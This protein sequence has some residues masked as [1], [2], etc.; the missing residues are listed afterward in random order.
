MTRTKLWLALASCLVLHSPSARAAA[1]FQDLLVQPPSIGTPQRGSLAGT[2][3]RLAFGPGDLARG[4]FVLPLPIDAPGDRGPLLA[5]VVP[6]YSAETGIG[7]WGVGWQADL[8]IRRYRSRGEVNFIDDEFTSPWGRLVAADDGNYY[9]AGLTSVIRVAPTGAGWI[10]QTQDGTTFSF[11]L[12]DA[13]V[14]PQGSF[15]W[16]LSRVDTITGDSTTL[17][18]THNASGR[19]FLTAV[20]W[21][22][23]GDGTQYRMTLDY[24]S[25]AS[26]FVSYTSGTKQL[27]DRRVSRVTVDVL[28]D[29]TYATRWRYDLAYQTSPSGPAFYLH[30][31]TRTFASGQ[32]DPSITYDYDFNVE[33]FA[34]AQLVH[35]PGLDG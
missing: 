17:D 3:S 16:M 35:A 20:H 15:A 8:A 7:E 31:I 27:L 32:A 14:T 11:D 2:L 33:R 18:W 28:A 19:P 4:A 5:K 24:T 22:G 25:L 26:P 1:P 23:R 21:G 6:S 10:A 29:G 30:Q 12:V 13:V 34:T 9:P